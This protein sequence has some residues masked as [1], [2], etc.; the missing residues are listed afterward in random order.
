MLDIIVIAFCAVSFILGFKDGFVRKLI[1]TVGFFFSVFLGIK[2]AQYGGKIIS[3]MMGSEPGFSNAFGGFLIFVLCMIATAF[4]KRWVHPFDKVNNMINKIVGGV[5][6]TIQIL[7]FMSAAFYI[8]NIFNYPS[9][10]VREKSTFYGSV[11]SVMPKAI[12][13]ISGASSSLPKTLPKSITPE[14]K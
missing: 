5:A 7:I 12:E 6:G 3:S 1:G 9:K 2:L 4:I 10:P 14:S 11:Y 8:L 13:F